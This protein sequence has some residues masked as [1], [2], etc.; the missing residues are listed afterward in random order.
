MRKSVFAFVVLAILASAIP[1]SAQ[2]ARSGYIPQTPDGWYYAIQGDQVMMLT[3]DNLGMVRNLTNELRSVGPDLRWNGSA[4]GLPT[5]NGGFYPMYDRNRQPLSGR[6]RIER[7]AGIVVAADGVRRIINNPRGAAGWIEAAVGAVLVNDSRYRGQPRNQQRDNGS[8]VVPPPQSGG[9]RDHE[10]RTG[11]DGIPVAIGTRPGATSPFWGSGANDR[12]DC[13]SQEMITLDNQSS[14]PLRVFRNGERFEILLPKK[15]VCAPLEG[16][17]TGEIVGTV[18]GSDG[19][20][21]RVGEAPAKPE[22]RPGL[23]LVWR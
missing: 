17:Y 21:G 8:V 7:G 22:S 10:V 20:T 14:G 13:M 2:F 15:Q 1:A 3:A 5:S 16:N 6:Q 18:V 12:P 9:Q 11:P 19:L 23:I 4:Y